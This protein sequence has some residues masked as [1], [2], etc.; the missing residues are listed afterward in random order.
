[1]KAHEDKEQCRVCAGQ[2]VLRDVGGG[3]GVKDNTVQET[4]SSELAAV[5]A[6]RDQLYRDAM[7]MAGRLYLEKDETFA[8]ETIEVMTRWR[9]KVDR[10][11]EYPNEVRG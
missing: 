9:L 6:E 7:I 11:L 8:P 3:D 2:Q 10:Q 5:Y 4:Y 1:M